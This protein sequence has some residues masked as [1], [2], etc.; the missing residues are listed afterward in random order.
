MELLRNQERLAGLGLVA[1]GAAAVGWICRLPGGA[2]AAAES[3]LATPAI[4]VGVC[5]ILAPAL[6]IGMS[7]AG[8]QTNA[9]TFVGALLKSWR[10]SG[11]VALGLTPPLLFLVATTR[12]EVVA[13]GF[14]VLAL[15]CAM[16]IGLVALA[17]EAGEHSGASYICFVLW[18]AAALAVGGKLFFRAVIA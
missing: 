7:L 10:A 6:Y 4:V 8:A 3:S 17:K 12:S 2:L 16:F 18:S 1:V 14:G 5:I 13:L 15:A 9:A 11:L